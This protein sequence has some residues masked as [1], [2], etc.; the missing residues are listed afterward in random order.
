MKV[1]Y[2]P[3]E[4]EARRTVHRLW[5]NEALP[6]E[7]AQVLPTPEHFQQ[8]TTLVTEEMIGDSVAC[9]PDLDR[10]VEM[11]QQHADAGVDELYVQ[12]VGEGHD[13]FFAAYARDVLPRFR[14]AAEQRAGHR[15]VA[16]HRQREVA[17]VD[18][19][20]ARVGRARATWLQR[21]VPIGEEAVGDAVGEGGAEGAR[22]RVADRDRGQAARARIDA[23]HPGPQRVDQRRL[24]RRRVAD[25]ATP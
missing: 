18:A 21:H 11:I 20:V 25:H 14:L 9:G 8:A 24:D 23:R 10:H 1:C 15:A 5:P 22:V 7:L 19:L 13:E 2:G 17:H 6:G 3:D 12:Q 16:L 4:T